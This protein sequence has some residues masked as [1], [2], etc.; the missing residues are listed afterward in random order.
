M[1]CRG[2]PLSF[3]NFGPANRWRLARRLDSIAPY[4]WM[5]EDR[6]DVGERPTG[7]CGK[8]VLREIAAAL[9]A[10]GPHTQCTEVDSHGHKDPEVGSDHQ[11]V[12]I[13][14]LGRSRPA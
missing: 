7:R 1:K 4:P 6:G 10:P 14:K 2:S 13:G 3:C 9:A 8:R 5:R 12:G 11:R